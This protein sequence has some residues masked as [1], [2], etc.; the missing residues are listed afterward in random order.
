MD[1]Q[2]V[3]L[4]KEHLDDIEEIDNL[5]FHKPWSITEFEKE[6][7]NPIA[8]Y[9]V[10]LCNN[11]VVGYGGFWWV[12][13]EAEITNIAVHPDFRKQG[14]AQKILT[15]MEQKCKETSTTLIHLEVRESNTPARKLY[16]KVGFIQDGLRK[17]YYSDG[18]NAVL[19][20]K[21]IEYID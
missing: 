20:T 13:F 4:K 1:I 17:G 15:A 2:I 6:L 8:T 7:E 9:Y 14:I 10:A 21:E 3:Y 11:K 5:C 12:M 19:M 16:E 18:E